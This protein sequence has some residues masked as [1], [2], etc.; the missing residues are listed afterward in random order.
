MCQHEDLHGD[1]LHDYGG[2]EF[3]HINYSKYNTQPYRYFYGCGFRHLV[4]DS[5]LKIDLKDKTLKVCVMTMRLCNRS[6]CCSSCLPYATLQVWHQKGFYPSEPVF[7]PSPDAVEE[8]DGV[9]LSVVLTPS[10]VRHWYAAAVPDTFK[11]GD[12]QPFIL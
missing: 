1:D 11:R 2:L 10:Q 3:P 8:D 4:G 12:V 6:S 5:L 9:I 7:V